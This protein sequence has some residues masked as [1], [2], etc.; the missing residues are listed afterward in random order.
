MSEINNNYELVIQYMISNLFP[1][2][3]LQRQKIYLCRGLYKP[4]GTNIHESIFRINK[5]VEYLNKL[6]PFGENKG[7]TEDEII[8]HVDFYPA[9][10][11]AEGNTCSRI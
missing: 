11:A 5:I 2:K 4:H 10:E 9:T 6:P 8:E 3:V 1:P 7:F